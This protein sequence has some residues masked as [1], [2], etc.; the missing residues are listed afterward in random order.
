MSEPSN[1]ARVLD[2]IRAQSSATLPLP[3]TAAWLPSSGG[4]RSAESGGPLDQP[5][6]SGAPVAAGR[7]AQLGKLRVPIGP[8]DD[9][10]RADDS[11]KFLARDTELAVV[12]RADRQDHR[13]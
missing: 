6:N 12:R 1:S 11:G 13:I 4:A 7:R 2:R 10:G 3:M 9:L 8:A 5:T